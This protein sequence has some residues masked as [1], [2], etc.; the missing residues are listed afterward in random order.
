MTKC[1]I[2]ALA[3]L[4]VF[5]PFLDETKI[6]HERICIRNNMYLNVFVCVYVCVCVCVYLCV[7]LSVCFFCVCVCVCVCLC[8]C[9][10]VC[11]CVRAYVCEFETLHMRVKGEIQLRELGRVGVTAWLEYVNNILRRYLIMSS[12]K[13]CLS[14][15]ALISLRY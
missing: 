14:K 5:F 11:V 7:C 2:D 6:A 3:F 1:G 13:K 8:V 15:I 10:F 9:L 4:F 12:H